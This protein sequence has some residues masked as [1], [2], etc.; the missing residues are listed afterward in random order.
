MTDLTSA[1]IAEVRKSRKYRELDLPDETLRD[2][3]EQES[4][5]H[6]SERETL[7]AARERLHNLVAPYLGDPDYPVAKVQLEAAYSSGNPEAIQIICAELLK[8]H[9]STRER[10]AYQ[11]EF[12][13]AIFAVTG[14]PSTLLDLACGLNPLAFGWMGLPLTTQY[15][16]YDLHQPRIELINHYFK[17]QG[18][19]ELAEHGDILVN[20]PQIQAEVAFFF[21]EAHR[22]EQRRRGCNRE[23]WLAL[24]VNWLVVTLPASS[25]TGRHDLAVGHRKL[26]SE[27]LAGLDWPMTE[28]FVGNE[29]IFCIHKGAG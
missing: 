8:T 20:T 16:A 13:A 26:V 9:A 17:L 29:L 15:H 10:L 5:R 21:K 23:F 11:L 24:N 18:L 27:T 28:Q 4:G 22:F 12:Y 7:Q 6:K 14:V 1:F 25:L 2:L 3:I 19:G